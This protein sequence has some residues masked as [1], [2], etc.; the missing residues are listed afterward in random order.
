MAN[1]VMSKVG[2]KKW[3]FDLDFKQRITV[4]ISIDLQVTFFYHTSNGFNLK[5]LKSSQPGCGLAWFVIVF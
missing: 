4:N 2:C 5:I 3:G 1:S